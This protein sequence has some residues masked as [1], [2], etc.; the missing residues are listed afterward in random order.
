MEG[1]EESGVSGGKIDRS[2]GALLRISKG[3]I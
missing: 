2:K 1:R 3:T